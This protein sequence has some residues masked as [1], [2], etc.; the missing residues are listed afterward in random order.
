LKNPNLTEANEANE[1]KVR[2]SLPLFPSVQQSAKIGSADMTALRRGIIS[3]VTCLAGMVSALKAIRVVSIFAL[4]VFFCGTASAVWTNVTTFGFHNAL[5]IPEINMTVTIT[6]VLPQL[7]TNQGGLADTS[8]LTETTDPING[9]FF[10]TNL[11][12][13]SYTVRAYS[14][15]QIVVPTNSFTNDWTN[16][17][18]GLIIPGANAV[19]TRAQSDG[20]YFQTTNASVTGMTA[21]NTVFIGWAQLASAIFSNGYFD[22]ATNLVC[23]DSNSDL[24]GTTTIGGPL[25]FGPATTNL[26]TITASY[27]II[28]PTNMI[29]GKATNATVTL[30]GVGTNG[31]WEIDIT[32]GPLFTN[33][34]TNM[35]VTSQGVPAT[36]T[37]CINWA[38]TSTNTTNNL[39]TNTYRVVA[40]QWQ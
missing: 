36:N 30:S 22:G 15:T 35:V 19:Y 29:P 16:L 32:P 37:I 12:P 11:T 3:L 7:W 40:R 21:S 31:D 25:S 23:T 1:A 5:G 6:P 20:R 14:L 10:L 26:Q 2:S 27:T 38:N 13:G 9:E 33:T 18:S 39:G 28:G 4:F 8:P 24:I 17:I 34:A